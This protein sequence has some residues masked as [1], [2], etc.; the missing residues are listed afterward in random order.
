MDSKKILVVS[1]VGVRTPP[2]A[3]G[4]LERISADVA[5]GLAKDGNEV[6]MVASLDSS[7]DWY[8][9]NGVTLV[10]TVS[11]ALTPIPEDESYKVWKARLLN[12]K[13][14]IVI[15]QS[16]GHHTIAETQP[17]RG[18][19]ESTPLI[20]MF[21]DDVTGQSELPDWLTAPRICGASF[22]HAQRLNQAF[23]WRNPDGS[24]K[25]LFSCRAIHHGIDLSQY[26][27]Y[28]GKRNGRMCFVGRLNFLKGALHAID[29]ARMANVGLDL[30]G[31]SD[32]LQ[33]DPYV[34]VVKQYV[35]GSN[36]IY[37]GEVPHEK[38]VELMQHASVGIS[39]PAHVEAYGLV[40]PE[41]EATG[42]P[43]ITNLSGALP[44]LVPNE[45]VCSNKMRA[46]RRVRDIVAG[47]DRMDPHDYRDWVER[48]FS[49]ERMLSRYRSAISEA[50]NGVVW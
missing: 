39:T 36:I 40:A 38:K 18:M 45:N 10:P 47:L 2:P 15:D 43:I 30:V 21:H 27:L 6:W 4:G 32:H 12:E 49:L 23:G 24:F 34:A 48:D 29:I 25:N 14:D 19:F 1:S 26:P 37:H 41:F 5:A 50:M 8:Q 13:F 9:K 11:S 31:P 35:D 33:G 17:G 7:N 22:S 44:E 28:T 16:H 46:A 42:T 20:H 3:Y